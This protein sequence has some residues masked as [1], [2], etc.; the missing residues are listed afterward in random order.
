MNLGWP[1][2]EGH[3]YFSALISNGV[4]LLPGRIRGEAVGYLAGRMNEGSTLRPAKVADLESMYVRESHR[5]FGVGAGL[6]DGFLRWA[7]GKWA[8]R[9]SVTAYAAN[10]RAIKFYESLGF[11]PM[12]LSLEMEV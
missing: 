1:E 12:R 8:E 9:V 4:R 10:G 6:A 3:E 2:Q 5:S 11:R 7:E